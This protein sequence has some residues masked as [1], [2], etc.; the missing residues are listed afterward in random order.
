VIQV[1]P[2]PQ[3]LRVIQE[4]LESLVTVAIR[5]FPVLQVLLDIVEPLV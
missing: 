2:E 4:L 1:F 3:V 5:A